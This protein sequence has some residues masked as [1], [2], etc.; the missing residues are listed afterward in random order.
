MIAIMTTLNNNDFA[1]WGGVIVGLLAITGVGFLVCK[2]RKRTLRDKKKKKDKSQPEFPV[3]VVERLKP[4]VARFKGNFGALLGIS[5]GNN[6]DTGYD[7]MIFQNIADVISVRCDEH[8]K[9]WF[10]KF[11][12][13][14]TA[15]DAVIY[16][17]KAN[18]LIKLFASCG[19]TKC[20]ETMDRWSNKFSMR[21]NSIVPIGEGTQCKIATPCWMLNG[22]V[23]EKGMVM[24]K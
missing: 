4:D 2:K 5:T 8:V 14:R 1:L 17:D 24:A 19:V 23:I 15:W 3:Y 18:T 6:E 11:T 10:S 22:I 12:E 13:N 9:T 16:K 20:E 7:D 21:Y